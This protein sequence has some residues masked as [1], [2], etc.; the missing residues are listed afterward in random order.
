MLWKV[1]LVGILNLRV[2][3]FVGI[4][5]RLSSRGR[6]AVRRV[7]VLR[8]WIALWCHFGVV[9]LET[10][11]WFSFVLINWFA[12]QIYLLI[13]MIIVRFTTAEFRSS[14]FLLWCVFFVWLL[15]SKRAKISR[16]FIMLIIIEVSQIRLN[17]EFLFLSLISIAK[18]ILIWHRYIIQ[19][20]TIQ[21]I[22]LIEIS[23]VILYIHAIARLGSILNWWLRSCK[24][25]GYRT[26][27]G[28][29]SRGHCCCVAP[30]AIVYLII[31]ALTQ[32][33]GLHSFNLLVSQVK[34]F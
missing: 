5:G 9:L 27:Q 15:F 17:W 1:Q 28:S 19:P 14:F 8:I 22:S 16:S 31:C 21:A 12:L 4:R 29:R 26:T 25:S 30:A 18:I 10:F 6:L 2:L 20:L 33:S 13:I 7:W 3:I 11:L 34:L 24:S 23:T 32:L